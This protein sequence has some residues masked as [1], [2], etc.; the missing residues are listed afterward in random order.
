M[1]VERRTQLGEEGEGV[2]VETREVDLLGEGGDKHFI[3]CITVC[4]SW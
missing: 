3:L 4:G 2:E 1:V